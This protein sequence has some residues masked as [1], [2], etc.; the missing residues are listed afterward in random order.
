MDQLVDH[1]DSTQLFA[2]CS[3][4]RSDLHY[5]GVKQR[6]SLE[7]YLWRHDRR[8][9][10]IRFAFR[11]RSYRLQARLHGKRNPFKIKTCPLCPLGEDETEDHHLL[12][13]PAFFLE[14]ICFVM[15]W[16]TT[17]KIPSQLNTPTLPIHRATCRLRS[18]LVEQRHTGLRKLLSRSICSL[19]RISWLWL[20]RENA[21]WPSSSL[22][23]DP[24]FTPLCRMGPTVT[25]RRSNVEKAIKPVKSLL[26]PASDDEE[27]PNVFGD[28]AGIFQSGPDGTVISGSQTTVIVGGSA[29]DG[30]APVVGAGA[31]GTGLSLGDELAQD[32]A[33][34]A[35]P[36]IPLRRPA[37]LQF[38]PL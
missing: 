13:C 4:T 3:R 14:R 1:A 26:D 30:T 5:A 38:L 19:D 36:D 20:T 22:K 11:S 16:P 8:S 27:T 6:P 33:A 15:L 28:L 31:I 21:F 12:C 35:L 32:Y 24:A 9:A 7:S 29:P 18:S 34:K 17:C 10:T 2:D 23:P 37:P 25:C